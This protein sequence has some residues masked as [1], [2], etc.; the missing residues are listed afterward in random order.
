M[1]KRKILSV[2]A[3]V[4][5]AV[6]LF[7]C[8]KKEVETLP[9][10]DKNIAQ[11]ECALLVI[12]K[13]AAINRIDG[14]KP[15]LLKSWTTNSNAATLL[16][17]AG[18]HTFIFEYAQSQE[19][20]AAKKLEY[21][22]AMSAGKMYILSAA[23]D[24]RTAGGVVSTVINVT[25]SFV[26]DSIIDLL[27]FTDMLPRSNP[28]GIRFQ[29][30]EI[31]QAA[32]DQ[33]LLNGNTK[34]AAGIRLLCFL[35]GVLWV[36]IIFGFSMLGSFLFMKK[37]HNSHPFYAITLGIGLVVAGIIILNY[38]SNGVLLLNLLATLLVGFGISGLDFSTF[39]NNSG[40]EKLEKED[41]TGAVSDFSN[42]IKSAPNNA[43]Y[44][45]NRGIAYSRLQDWEKAIADFTE[46]G[47]LNPNND[48]Y[49]KNLADA[50]AQAA[51]ESTGVSSV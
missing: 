35:L 20:W 37:F 9:P 31:D 36:I 50:Q 43:D 19:G 30:N 47:R 14:K 17:P 48:T 26:R 13:N 25:T 1:N 16:V 29:I 24:E 7:G 5:F 44:L 33:Y 2:F 38:N 4:L 23:M 49:K 28:K 51:K 27:P 22:A 32:F 45:N 10:L 6:A 8:A 15:G 39:S 11:E 34:M 41:Y 18:E 21:T 12:P 40:V 46:A 3:A 42:A